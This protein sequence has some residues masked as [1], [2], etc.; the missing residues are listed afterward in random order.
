[1]S[2]QKRLMSLGDWYLAFD[3]LLARERKDAKYKCYQLNQA[4]DSEERARLTMA[5]VGNPSAHIESPFFCDYGYNI[6]IGE[7]FY[8]NHGCTILDGAKITIGDNCMI[9]PHVVISTTSHPLDVEKRVEGYE[10]SLPITIGD[11]V[12]IGANVTILGGVK[13]GDNV[14]IGAGSLVNKDLPSNSVCV[15]T[16]AKPIK[17]CSI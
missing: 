4:F 13:I 17:K 11:N 14:I 5:L 16:P 15:G 8:A 3:P 6:E 1:V 12:W 10:Q 9:A 2:E 7:N